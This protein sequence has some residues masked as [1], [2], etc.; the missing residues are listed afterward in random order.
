M[1]NAVA[2]FSRYLDRIQAPEFSCK[3][4]LLMVAF[5][6]GLRCHAAKLN[7]LELIGESAELS[8][9]HPRIGN[10]GDISC[11]WGHCRT[12][13]FGCSHE[14]TKSVRAGKSVVSSPI[15]GPTPKV[16]R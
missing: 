16:T 14:L 15:R 13:M 6:R 2:Q 9:A 12:C 3:P 11:P 5:S 4:G 8:R 10:R 1:E 7:R